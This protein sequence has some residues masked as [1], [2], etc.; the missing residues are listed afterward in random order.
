L[1]N[2]INAFNE[3]GLDGLKARKSRSGRKRKLTEDQIGEVRRWLDEGPSESQG[4]FFWTGEKLMKEIERE[5]G[6]R[7]SLDGV[8]WL[9]KDL[10][11]RRIVPKTRHYKSD[12]EA[13]EEFK[14]NSR[15]W[16]RR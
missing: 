4:C 9:L 15:R 13:A 1:R 7:Y 3:H 6:V 2:W 8:Y 10:G 14:K 5:F 16:S 11:Y 12:P